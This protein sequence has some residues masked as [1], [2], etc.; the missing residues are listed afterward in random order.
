MA[1]TIVEDV[2]AELCQFLEGTGGQAVNIKLDFNVTTVMVLWKIVSNSYLS[3]EDEKLRRVVHLVD[4]TFQESSGLMARIK[5]SFKPLTYLLRLFGLLSKESGLLALR[6]FSQETFEEHERS[7]QEDNM[8]DFIDHYLR[9]M[10]EKSSQEG[11]SSFKGSDGRLNLLNLIMDMFLAG[12][13]TTGITMTW[14]V[15]YMIIHPEAQ[16]K[17][18][19]EVDKVTGRSRLPKPSDRTET[20]YTEAVIHEVQVKYLICHLS[21]YFLK[22][23]N[24][25][26]MRKSPEKCKKSNT[27]KHFRCSLNHPG[28]K[29]VFFSSSRECP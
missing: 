28:I 4:K 2:S 27:K 10:H 5:H 17:V 20:P 3:R 7:F 19:Q 24:K 26:V 6:K 11:N 23:E 1:D 15:L 21:K 25:R 18:Q 16:L 29:G 8:R 12:G 14:L 13:E 9:E 22:K